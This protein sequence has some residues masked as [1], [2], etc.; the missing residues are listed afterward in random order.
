MQSDEP[1]SDESLQIET[2]VLRLDDAAGI[3]PGTSLE[4]RCAAAG[5]SANNSSAA[6]KTA[7]GAMSRASV[8]HTWRCRAPC[9]AQPPE[10]VSLGPEMSGFWRGNDGVSWVPGVLSGK[11]LVVSRHGYVRH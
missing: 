11:S 5:C 8:A 1:V 10:F 3:E 6:A 4:R 9:G 7:S 2:G